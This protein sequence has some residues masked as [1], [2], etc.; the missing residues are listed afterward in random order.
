VVGLLGRGGMGEVYQAE[1]TVLGQTVALKL[2]P[3]QLS[4]DP[5]SRQ[6]LLEEVRVARRV[7]HP[8][9]CRVHDVGETDGR[10]FIS[11]ELVPGEDLAELLRRIGRLAGEKALEIARQV[12]A[13]LAAAH[14]A[15][16]LHRDLKPA[17]VMLDRQGRARLTDFGL[18]VAGEA[19]AELAGTPA[20]MAPEQ[21]AGLPASERS[22]LYALGL[23][24]Y[25]LLCG[26]R[27]YGGSTLDEL[28]S[29]RQEPPPLPSSVVSDIE[30][31]VEAVIMQ[32]L[33]RNPEDRPAS[34]VTVLAALSGGDPLAAAVAAGQTPSPSAVAGT[35][36]SG[37]VRPAVV[38]ACLASFAIGLAIYVGLAPRMSVVE[39]SGLELPPE[40]MAVRARDLLAELGYPGPWRDQAWGFCWDRGTLTYLV[41]GQRWQE[42]EAARPPAIVFWYRVSPV[43]MRPG[44][45]RG[46][47]GVEEPPLTTGMASVVLDPKGRLLRLSARP[48]SDAPPAAVPAERLLEL[49]GL[50]PGATIPDAAPTP[51]LFAD[52]VHGWR[53]EDGEQT[54]GIEVA[55]LA[56]RPVSFDIRGP[57]SRSPAETE[58]RSARAVR[59]AD[60]FRVF[61]LIALLAA[62]FLARDNL[63]RRRGDRG[64]ATRIAALVFCLA[65]AARL[66]GADHRPV[67]A[68]ELDVLTMA[69][70]EGLFLAVSAWLYYVALEPHVRRLWPER[71]VSWARL[72]EGRWR[73]P[74]VGRDVLAGV[75]VTFATAVLFTIGASLG[76]EPL[77]P[78]EYWLFPLLGLRYSLTALLLAMVNAVSAGLWLLVLLL[79]LRLLP[80]PQRVSAALLTALL[81][82][83]GFFLM[84][85]TVRE[86]AILQ[87]VL[88]VVAALSWV[89]LIT[90]LGLL[91]MVSA[92]CIQSLSLLLPN[93]VSF[94]TWHSEST[95]FGLSV[96]TVLL[97]L[98]A[99]F[100]VGDRPLFQLK[101]PGDQ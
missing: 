68:W 31:R 97:A 40:A 101:V 41:A 57:W 80:I 56:G 18:A 14:D 43:L 38:W 53:L 85:A 64:G 71:L 59:G 54:L 99:R 61:E 5:A 46:R 51:H 70:G 89:F 36:A 91:A 8:N 66:L 93:A 82:F 16:V 2:L 62:V 26:T 100:A 17:N 9:V 69:L 4:R 49:A 30:P 55:M 83:G 94:G 72:L 48:A 11:M 98:G 7:S 90:R 27:A 44:G 60:A 77:T 58:Q 21:L 79:V 76:G 92:L 39:R 25:E 65:A 95:W 47:I 23:L 10:L 12:T 87:A 22:D 19:A 50:E 28:R 3:A 29:S 1:D 52:A 45:R 34:A 88:A 6:R 15:G 37:A 42:L 13:G 86:T 20:Y 33:A 84:G 35:T 32:C 75:V 96:V 74:M 73:D 81:A 67:L 24:L 78:I 63:R